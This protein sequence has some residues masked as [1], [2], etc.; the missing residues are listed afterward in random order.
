MSCLRPGPASDSTFTI[1]GAPWMRCEPRP[2]FATPLTT[3]CLE[4][5]SNQMLLLSASYSSRVSHSLA[6]SHSH[7]GSAT[8]ASQSKV[9]KV[10]VRGANFW[11]GIAEPPILLAYHLHVR[12]IPFPATHP[13]PG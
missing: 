5:A 7:G 1:P 13:E 12:A 8:C 10:L 11:T 2:E 6:R 4:S 9:G 3:S